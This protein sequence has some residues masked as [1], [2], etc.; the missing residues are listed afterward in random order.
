MKYIV[1]ITRTVTATAEIAISASD[2]DEASEKAVAKCEKDD[3]SFEW[4]PEDTSYE[5]EDVNEE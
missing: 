5:A 4:E 2:E 3:S 1:K